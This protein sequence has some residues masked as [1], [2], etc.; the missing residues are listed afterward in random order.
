M[1]KFSFELGQGLY[2]DN[3]Y[4]SDFDVKVIKKKIYPA[5]SKMTFI[6]QAKTLDGIILQEREVSSL[7]NIN[8][9]NM[10]NEIVDADLDRQK[11]KIIEEHMQQSTNG[12]E[13]EF[14]FENE[15]NGLYIEAVKKTFLIM[16]DRV[17]LKEPNVQLVNCASKFKWIA[18]EMIKF[19]AMDY[20]DEFINAAPGCSEIVFYAVMMSVGKPLLIEAGCDC[21][22][23]LNLYGESGSY[24]TSLLKAMIK[25][26]ESTADLTGSFVNS[27][28][29]QIIKQIRDG[30]GFPFLLDDFHP[31][32]TIYTQNRQID[33][34]DAVVREIENNPQTS[35]V[36]M[37]SEYLDGSFSLQDRLVQIEMPKIE[38]SKLN[39]IQNNKSNMAIVAWKFVCALWENYDDVKRRAKTYF[40]S[41]YK[42]K[43]DKY[44]IDQYMNKLM[45]V[46][47][48]FKVYLCNDDSFISKEEILK[49]AF[50]KQKEMQ[51]RHMLQLKKSQEDID[52]AYLIIEMI[53]NKHL[54]LT[55]SSDDYR[56]DQEL[57]QGFEKDG[58]YIFFKKATLRF[59]I[60]SY[61]KK[62]NV[63]ISKVVKLLDENGIL[64]EDKDSKTKKI[65]GIRHICISY[66]SLKIY[67]ELYLKRNEK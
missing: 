67:K 45:F 37:S 48:L 56:S 22:I 17:L 62:G 29:K 58:E 8:F 40:S 66:S 51:K 4:V 24:K 19:S 41:E 5:K 18:K 11:R 54:L 46:H 20:A 31:T 65:F 23:V 44:R 12:V 64:I 57:F 63:S 9:F 25:L 2:A 26:T 61:L 43:A 59:A 6:L 55:S 13:E 1:K 7:K 34:M 10:W 14:F 53:E 36:F 16:G 39:H 50:L 60:E 27:T 42:I 28:K 52:Y 38:L 21:D 49:T 35:I 33:I 15:N 32:E 47:E 3:C 30:F